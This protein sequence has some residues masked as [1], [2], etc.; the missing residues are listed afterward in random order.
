MVA[1]IFMEAEEVLRL[2]K[3]SLSK[4]PIRPEQSNYVIFR[5]HVSRPILQLFEMS[6]CIWSKHSWKHGVNI[7]IPMQAMFRTQSRAKLQ[8]P[9]HLELLRKYDGGSPKLTSV[10]D[11]RCPK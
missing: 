5:K 6:R 10:S 9:R 4:S 8:S 2:A 1:D 3:E 7:A 11:V